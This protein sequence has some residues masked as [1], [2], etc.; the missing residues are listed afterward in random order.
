MSD[1]TSK[2]KNIQ[3][4]SW[5]KWL[6]GLLV[7]VLTGWVGFAVYNLHK[8]GGDSQKEF[9]LN[10]ESPVNVSV[11]FSPTLYHG[12][13]EKH[14][15]VAIIYDKD[16]MDREM[17]RLQLQLNDMVTKAFEKT[18]N[19]QSE[20]YG[21]RVDDT[22]SAVQGIGLI[23]AI[24]GVLITVL[25][26]YFSIS[27]SETLE[28]S[29]EVAVGDTQ[30]KIRDMKISV[31]RVLT[32]VEDSEEKLSAASELANETRKNLEV[33]IFKAQKELETRRIQK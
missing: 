27:N 5:T 29:I 33:S 1:S 8:A 10:G 30:N 7:L 6:A 32:Q 23:S 25:V 19:D 13:Y 20:K 2:S 14:G 3:S 15:D 28:K 9:K 18:L 24:I 11:T 17:A 21:K 26:L 12:Q 16:A 31:S 22:W 4:H